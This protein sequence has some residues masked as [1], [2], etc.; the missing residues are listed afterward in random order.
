MG[1]LDLPTKYFIISPCFL[2]SLVAHLVKNLPAMQENWVQSLA[3]EYPL[4]K[5]KATHSSILTWRIPWTVQS[6]GSQRVRHKWV[7]VIPRRAKIFVHSCAPRHVQYYLVYS[8]CSTNICWTKMA[9]PPLQSSHRCP[10]LRISYALYRSHH[11]MYYR[12]LLPPLL[13]ALKLITLIME[14][15]AQG[16]LMFYL[17]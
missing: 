9:R 15:A 5:D 16:F 2:A 7:K 11:C 14:Q 3:W 4:E 1:I 13:P 12:L 8:K 10:F 17:I 6:T